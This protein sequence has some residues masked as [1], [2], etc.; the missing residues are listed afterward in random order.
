MAIHGHTPEPS[1]LSLPAMLLLL[2]VFCAY[3][4]AQTQEYLHPNI[5]DVTKEEW[6]QK[7][8]KQHDMAF[9]GP[10]SFMHLPYAKCLEDASQ[11]FDI[12]ILGLPFDTTTSYRPGARFGP[13]SIR[14][15]APGGGKAYTLAWGAGVYDFGARLVDCGDVPVTPMDNAKAIDQ[16]E[17]AY[18]TLLARPVHGATKSYT[19]SMAKD[20]LEHPRIVTLGGDH[21]IVLPI[22]RSLHKVYGP[23]SV[24]HF[25]AHFDTADVG[26]VIGPERISHGSY[27][28]I[29]AEENLMTNHSIHA[30]IRQKMGG[31]TMVEHDESVGFAVISSEDMDDY[32]IDAVIQRIRQRV[33][34]GPVYLSFDIDTIDPAMAPATGT[35]E[36]GGW[37]TREVKRIMRG[38]AGLNFVGVDMVEV[39]PAYDHAEITSFAAT[40]IILD[41]LMMMQA[42]SPPAS[43]VTV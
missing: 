16:M 38:L 25:D 35:P 40:S 3:V 27:F 14:A 29:A 2:L 6:H 17:V 9:T 23:V 28:T 36:A 10:L 43:H 26:A 7:Y 32:G 22:L 19:A 1:L 13:R 11:P 4:A 12:A 30:G 5:L 20:G 37:T 21:T 31:K 39:A 41:F 42:D 24:I 34:T 8:G 15:A 33:G 18:S